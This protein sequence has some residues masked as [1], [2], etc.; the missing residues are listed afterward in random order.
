MKLTDLEL[1][2]YAQLTFRL[3][4]AIQVRR[5]SGCYILTTLDEEI[6][7]IGQT[8]TLHDRFKQHL[9]DPRMTKVTPLGKAVWFAHF[10]V[11]ERELRNVESQLLFQHQVREGRL[12]YLNRAGP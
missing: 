8:T 6:L 10:P 3:D 1:S 12:P 9:A 4:A 11:Q 5:E 7:Y 2:H